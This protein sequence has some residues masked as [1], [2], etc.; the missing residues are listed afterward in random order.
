MPG[1]IQR[2]V[3]QNSDKLIP[4]EPGS[5]TL[6][7]GAGY[8]DPANSSQI[9]V[10]VL[11]AVLVID[12]FQIICIRH[13]HKPMSQRFTAGQ[14][15]LR[16]PVERPPAVKP[17]EQ[18][19]VTFLFNPFFLPDIIRYIH[20]HPQGTVPSRK[21]LQPDIT[22]L[23]PFHAVN[24]VFT[25]HRMLFHLFQGCLKQSIIRKQGF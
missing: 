23:L 13:Q 25:F 9:P 1:L 4:A 19:H 6:F 17:C 22:D 7:P 20:D 12:L 15:S 18:I 24:S 8:E 5:Y 21:C 10:S 2:T 16:L 3:E 11:V 14:K